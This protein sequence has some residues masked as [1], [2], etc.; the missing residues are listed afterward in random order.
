M[1]SGDWNGLQEEQEVQVTRG[2]FNHEAIIIGTK[3]TSNTDLLIK[4]AGWLTVSAL[5]VYFLLAQKWIKA[6][7]F[8]LRG[9]R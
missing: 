7:I 5:I 9:L 2:L 4:L 6:E 3:G 1:L 8:Q